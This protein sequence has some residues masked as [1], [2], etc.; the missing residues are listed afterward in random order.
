ML[1]KNFDEKQK[2]TKKEYYNLVKD[3]LHYNIGT[4]YKKRT[5]EYNL[6]EEDLLTALNTNFLDL[7]YLKENGLACVGCAENTVDYLH[8]PLKGE[9][10]LHEQKK[11]SFYIIN[12][13][14][15]VS[16]I[17]HKYKDSTDTISYK[18]LV[19]D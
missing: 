1:L 13:N 10:P 17:I 6:S 4:I 15:A 12:V 5:G 19:K 7:E 16:L 11:G 2:I 14:E 9:R 18:V 8:K 3:T